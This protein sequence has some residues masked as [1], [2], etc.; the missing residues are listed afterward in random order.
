MHQINLWQRNF[1]QLRPTIKAKRLR[2]LNPRVSV[3][4]GDEEIN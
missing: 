4:F 2:I 1:S 3:E